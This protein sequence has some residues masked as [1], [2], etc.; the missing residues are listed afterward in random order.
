MATVQTR[1]GVC[2]T[3]GGQF[4]LEHIG[5]DHVIGA[6]FRPPELKLFC[7]GSGLPPRHYVLAH[8]D[9]VQHVRTGRVGTYVRRSHHVLGT[10]DLARVRWDGDHHVVIVPCSSILLL[11][12]TVGIAESR[13][14]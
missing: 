8:G 11:G 7:A 14:G 5:A 6:H 3:C 2:P 12:F 10:G 9:R 13:R 1:Y 4:K